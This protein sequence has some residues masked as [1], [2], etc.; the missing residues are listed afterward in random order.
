MDAA[1]LTRWRSEHE[2]SSDDELP[3]RTT[4]R[5]P[6]AEC[7]AEETVEPGECW[8]LLLPGS[9]SMTGVACTACLLTI[10]LSQ[11][12]FFPARRCD[13]QDVLQAQLL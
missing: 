3:S 9:W 8:L 1:P 11:A 7:M 12:S 2:S 4:P 13:A 10:E 5:E 6:V